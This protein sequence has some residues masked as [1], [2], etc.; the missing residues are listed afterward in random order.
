M[1]AVPALSVTALAKSYRGRTV[2]Q[3]VYL[4]VGKGEVVVIMGP[5]GCG[6]STLLRC[7]T[8][9][10][11][12]SD[13]FITVDGKPFGRALRGEVV[14]HQSRREIDA[15]RPRIGMVF[16]QFNLWPHM[17]ALENV[18]RPQVVVLRRPRAEATR[19]A[20]DLLAGL[21]LSGFHDRLPFALSGGQRQRVAIARALAMDPAVMLFD[22]PTSALDPELVGGV[23]ALLRGLAA[24]GITMMVVTHEVGFAAQV[25]D[26]A[27]FMDGGRIVE[28]GPAADVLR[29][30]RD[31]RLAAFLFA[32][33]GAPKPPAG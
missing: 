24:D 5:S 32:I 15:V 31:P 23:L 10:D 28:T 2:L 26:R 13:G 29:A 22:E 17:T 21:G 3:D 12:P 20:R 18:V 1:T 25:A 14:R 4:D 27:V 6:K 33:G 9:L 16:Q 19:K 7:I 8:W 30:P 11:P